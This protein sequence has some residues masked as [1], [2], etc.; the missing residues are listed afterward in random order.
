MSVNASNAKKRRLDHDKQNHAVNS[1]NSSS[2][3][4]YIN[5]GGAIRNVRRSLL[6]KLRQVSHDNPLC[7]LLLRGA[8]HWS[9]VPTTTD[10]DGTNTVRIYVDRNPDAFDDLLE[11]VEYGVEFLENIIKN[12]DDEA[13]YRLRKLGLECDYFTVDSLA[14]DVDEVTRRMDDDVD[15]GEPVSFRS[16][17]WFSMAGQLSHRGFNGGWRWNNISGNN[18]SIASQNTFDRD[19]GDCVVET[20]ATYLLI[21]SL[22]T[23]ATAALS[24]NR[25]YTHDDDD[26]FSRIVVYPGVMTR[27]DSQFSC[28][29]I[30]RCGA[31][32]YRS[33]EET[34]I[35]DPLLYTASFAEVISLRKGNKLGS[36]H[37]SG[38]VKTGR[39]PPIGAVV[40]SRSEFP[41]EPECVHF[42]KLIRVFG[43]NME[44]WN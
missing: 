33:D 30:A 17:G 37:G 39:G 4:V 27:S 7:I 31:F 29:T 22:H 10:R 44:K 18:R 6:T 14:A 13:R 42:M 41:D 24:P 2:P 12:N 19:F 38:I 23:I 40:T 43:D 35:N 5:V 3:I 1:N 34:R 25:G 26:E 15:F 20:T 21:F 36:K 11:Y 9:D 8:H 32:D 28:Y 16:D